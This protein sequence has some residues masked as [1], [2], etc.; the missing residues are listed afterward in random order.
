[1]IFGEKRNHIGVDQY[2]R[3]VH[4]ADRSRPSRLSSRITAM[5]ASASAG[6]WSTKG[7]ISS[8]RNG[9]STIP[10]GSRGSELIGALGERIVTPIVYRTEDSHARISASDTIP[11]CSPAVPF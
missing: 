11:K 6:S 10:A 7:A 1:M 4:S 3:D 9:F 2:G 5:R 8:Y